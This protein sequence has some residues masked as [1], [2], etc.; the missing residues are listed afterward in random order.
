MVRDLS[1][2]SI[3][4]D[5]LLEN[6]LNNYI[7]MEI[8]LDQPKSMVHSSYEKIFH[9]SNFSVKSWRIEVVA[10]GTYFN[11]SAHLLY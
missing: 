7:I 11:L 5:R 9:R 10:L 1:R 8:R 2:Y 6:Y 4:L 3:F